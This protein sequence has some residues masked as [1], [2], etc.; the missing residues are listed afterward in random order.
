[1]YNLDVKSFVL[2]LMALFFW[3]NGYFLRIFSDNSEIDFMRAGLCLLLVA[4]SIKSVIVSR[5][6]D[7]KMMLKSKYV[8]MIF[9][10]LSIIIVVQFVSTY[11][12]FGEKFEAIVRAPLRFLGV[13]IFIPLF[14]SRRDNLVR[15]VNAAIV[16]TSIIIVC[17]QTLAVLA[18][19][20]GHKILV[21]ECFIDQR[22]GIARL[23]A[24]LAM[25]YCIYYTL[26]YFYSKLLY[27]KGLSIAD[28]LLYFVLFVVH[29]VYFMLIAVSRMKT[30]S[31]FA[32][33]V[34]YYL[35]R[36]KIRRVLLHVP[37]V[38]GVVVIVVVLSGDWLWKFISQFVDT[39]V[40]EAATKSDNVGV[41]MYA[42]E[43]YLKHLIR[44]GLLGIGLLPGS[45]TN[46][47]ARGMNLY[48]YNLADLGTIGMVVMYGVPSVVFVVVTYRKLFSALNKLCRTE[49]FNV[50]SHALMMVLCYRI[51]SFSHH[52][53]WDV[54]SIWLGLMLFVVSRMHRYSDFGSESFVK[55]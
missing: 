54:E 13:L 50:Q 35:Y 42:V 14:L 30:L 11:I 29:L 37:I 36:A 12:T 43:Y 18:P 27:E 51:V 32:V 48:G 44:S 24:K 31:I 25:T 20:L 45:S 8:H 46:N 38:I 4:I 39:I 19:N 17:L 1:M 15:S 53:F 55:T 33:M 21:E 9:W 40:S 6:A 3:S 28:R 22:F 34:G 52:F 7:V 41:R 16:T 49:C 10:L 5:G 26:F 23:T 2:L 47:L